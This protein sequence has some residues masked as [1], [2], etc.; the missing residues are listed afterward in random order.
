MGIKLFSNN[1]NNLGKESLPYYIQLI[2]DI[3]KFTY[4]FIKL[5]TVNFEKNG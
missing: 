5:H 3:I 1:Q 2:L 4:G